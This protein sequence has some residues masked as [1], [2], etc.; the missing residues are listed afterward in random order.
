MKS[1]VALVLAVLL[2]A[3]SQLT[4]EQARTIGYER[5]SEMRDGPSLHG[6]AL[7]SALEVTEH[8][9]GKYLVELTDKPRNLLWAVIVLPSGKAE[10]TRMA[11]DG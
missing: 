5:L 2:T 4:P 9:G 1:I 6:D 3:C 10:V 8:R 7:M 11:I